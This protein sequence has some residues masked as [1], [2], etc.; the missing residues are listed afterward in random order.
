MGG[1]REG[2]PVCSSKQVMRPQYKSPDKEQVGS[3][4]V[5]QL[6]N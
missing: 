2:V 5:I 1:G 3:S 6:N 4:G